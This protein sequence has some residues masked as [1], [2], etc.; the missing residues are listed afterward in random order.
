MFTVFAEGF[1]V[2][3]NIKL[4][5]LCCCCPINV[6]ELRSARVVIYRL[7]VCLLLC[8]VSLMKYTENQYAA[9]DHQSF[10]PLFDYML[11]LEIKFSEN[12]FWGLN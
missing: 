6:N 4:A 12:T 9:L 11:R 10:F 5:N 1:R 3:F 2:C 8:S 7:A